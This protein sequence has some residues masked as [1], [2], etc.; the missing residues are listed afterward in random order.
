[1]V[2]LVSVVHMHLTTNLNRIVEFVWRPCIEGG[3]HWD[4]SHT[5]APPPGFEKKYTVIMACEVAG[6]HV[7]WTF[8]KCIVHHGSS[9]GDSEEP[10]MSGLTWYS[11]VIPRFQEYL[12][13]DFGYMDT[14]P[15]DT[16]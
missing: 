1:M 9:M 6:F 11:M 2:R 5:P 3:W 4:F 15:G 10:D 8:M 14:Q 12:N 13:T 7:D 16:K